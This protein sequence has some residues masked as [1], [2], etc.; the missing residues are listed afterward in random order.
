MA[1]QSMGRSVGEGEAKQSEGR[2][3]GAIKILGQGARRRRQGTWS[4]GGDHAG[5]RGESSRSEI[6]ILFL[7]VLKKHRIRVPGLGIP[8]EED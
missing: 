8:K 1:L 5:N 3:E 6:E 2:G 7:L 4:L